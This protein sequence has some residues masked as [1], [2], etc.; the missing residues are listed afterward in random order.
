MNN[1]VRKY[2]EVQTANGSYVTAS[3]K[4]ASRTRAM[5]EVRE[6]TDN[7]SG[8]GSIGRW[9]GRR[10]GGAEVYRSR[11]KLRKGRRM[12]GLIHTGTLTG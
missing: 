4:P 1:K 3:M 5:C 9:G 12:R 6:Q 8:V 7:R 2:E 10:K 11:A